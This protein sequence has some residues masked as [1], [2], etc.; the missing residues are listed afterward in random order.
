MARRLG[1]VGGAA[2]APRGDPQGR[3]DEGR[4]PPDQRAA[5]LD[6]LRANPKDKE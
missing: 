1:M 6:Y 2:I 3:G 5:L 4:P